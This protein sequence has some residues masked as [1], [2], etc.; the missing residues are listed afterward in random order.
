MLNNEE[1]DN[2]ERCWKRIKVA[3]NATA[4]KV[5][6]YRKKKSKV[7][8][9]VSS[10]EEIQ[11][12]RKLKKKVN[13]AKSEILRKRWLKTYGEKNKMVKRCLT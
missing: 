13:D 7:S 9:S 6:G 2:V 8:V 3:Y 1:D 12:G 5:L 11:E 10:W 4:K